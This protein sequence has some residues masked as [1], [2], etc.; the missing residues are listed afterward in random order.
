[1]DGGGEPGEIALSFVKHERWQ[2]RE[3]RTA[4]L[5]S[6]DENARRRALGAR[7]HRAN[8]DRGK[9]R[10]QRR[11]D[12]PHRVRPVNRDQHSFRPEQEVSGIDPSG[13][14]AFSRH[15]RQ[16]AAGIW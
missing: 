3:R 11:Q 15:M 10:E 8:R 13:E 12:F 2:K 14:R 9:S 1:M 4:A 7:M 6:T 5:S 16:R